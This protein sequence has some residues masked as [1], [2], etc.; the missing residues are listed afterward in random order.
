M[1]YVF[2]PVEG[3]FWL[4]HA[5]GAQVE[6]L[7]IAPGEPGATRRFSEDGGEFGVLDQSG[8][9]LGHYRILLQAPW[10]ESVR[11]PATLPK[12]GVAHA[13]LVHGGALFA[14]G[15]GNVGESLWVRRDGR[16][17]D[18]DV[19]P[20][21]E[22]MGRRGKAIDALFVHDQELV[23]IDNILLPKWILVYPMKHG[24][25]TASV[26]KYSL[27]SHTTYE[28]VL[29]ATEGNHVY[30]VLSRGVNHGIISYHLALIGKAKFGEI[31]HWSGRI[32]QTTQELINEVEWEILMADD[33]PL[34]L[35]GDS[36][37]LELANATLKAWSK[38]H[39]RSTRNLG[40]MLGA[41]KNMT[42]C[43]DCLVLAL[44]TQGLATAMPSGTGDSPKSFETMFSTGFHAVQLKTLVTVNNVVGLASDA[45]GVYAIGHDRF[46]VLSYEWL[47]AG[48]LHC[49]TPVAKG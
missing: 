32:E 38:R 42:Y 47:D 28:T 4:C 31:R 18:W 25:D 16:Q 40:P 7:A 9:R 21:P 6:P 1:R 44:G 41:I 45:A 14:G 5:D 30:A 48:R 22:G 36:T 15:H 24:L 23:A 10:F 37:E 2:L 33:P 8:K 26:R 34:D 39:A 46:D 20:L 11:P 27:T 12:N 29:R 43:G 13:L 17:P 35:L 49:N 3:Q 19:V